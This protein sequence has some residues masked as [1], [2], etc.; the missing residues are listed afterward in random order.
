M[1]ARHPR[2]KNG[3]ASESANP[4]VSRSVNQNWSIDP[5]VVPEKLEAIRAVCRWVFWGPAGVSKE[6]MSLLIRPDQAPPGPD[7][8]FG[9]ADS[10][11]QLPAGWLCVGKLK[12]VPVC[13]RYKAHCG[14]TWVWVT[15]DGI[16]GLA[17][18]TLIVQN[19]ARVS[20][21]LADL[22]PLPAR[23]QPDPFRDDRLQG[24]G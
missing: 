8:H 2:R 21:Q 6:S 7:R 5:I 19:I 23:V 9:V 14:D 18:F 10:M 4:S 22:V 12:D 3:F 24:G 20:L 1:A 11:A 13:A 15:P 16:K 17:D